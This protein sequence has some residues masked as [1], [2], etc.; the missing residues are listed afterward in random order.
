MADDRSFPPALK[1]G[2]RVW[3]ET[4]Y[5]DHGPMEGPRI[6]VA[7][8]QGGMIT[9]S[10]EPYHSRPDLILYVVRWDNGQISRHY[11][12][13]LLPIGRFETR[14]KFEAA[15]KPTGNV[16]LT[17]GPSGGFRYV[18][19]AVQYDGLVQLST[20]DDARIWECVLPMVTKLGLPISTTRLPKKKRATLKSQGSPD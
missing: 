16:E 6:D 17:V 19:L 7:P 13:E 18:H 20:I 12:R 4:G 5:R 9:K 8:E 14:E 3:T 15:I 2:N 11:A 1:V 10:E